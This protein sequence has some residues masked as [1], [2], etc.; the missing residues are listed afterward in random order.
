MNPKY[1]NLYVSFL[2]V[3]CLMTGLL[4]Y[5]M[6]NGDLLNSIFFTIGILGIILS[7]ARGISNKDKN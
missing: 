2:V 4:F 3:C 1:K 7:V 6:N 5:K